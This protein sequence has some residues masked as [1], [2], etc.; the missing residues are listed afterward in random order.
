[1]LGVDLS[2]LITDTITG[3]REVAGELG[4]KGEEA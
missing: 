1:M 3:M 2:E 4:L